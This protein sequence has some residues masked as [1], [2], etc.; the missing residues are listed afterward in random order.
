MAD[1]VGQD[2]ARRSGALLMSSA[3]GIAGMEHS[4]QLSEAKWGTTGDELVQ[5]LIAAVAR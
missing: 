2:D 4:R 5:R 3:H 1:V